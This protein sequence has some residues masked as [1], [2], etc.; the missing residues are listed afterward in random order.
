MGAESFVLIG[1]EAEQ[2]ERPAEPEPSAFSLADAGGFVLL[3][4]WNK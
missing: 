1:A 2:L 3:I 4:Q